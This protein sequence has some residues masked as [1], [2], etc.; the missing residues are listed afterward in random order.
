MVLEEF[1][2]KGLGLRNFQLK[3]Y[4][5]KNSC[6][7]YSQIGEVLAL[8]DHLYLVSFVLL[9]FM[10]WPLFD[11]DNTNNNQEEEEAHLIK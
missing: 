8:V 1:L 7:F 2:V 5:K 3:I 6:G 10:V 11:E 4:K 9:L